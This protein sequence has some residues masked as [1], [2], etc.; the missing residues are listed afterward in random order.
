MASAFL[1]HNQNLGNEEIAGIGVALGGGFGTTDELCPVKFDKAMAT[2][3]KPGWT[4]A[5]KEEYDR[6][7]FSLQDSQARLRAIQH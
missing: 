5:V 4:N 7:S 1:D 2:K 3:D 6:I